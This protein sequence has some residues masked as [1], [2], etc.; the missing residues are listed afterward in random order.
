VDLTT[1]LKKLRLRQVLT[2]F[3]AGLLLVVSTAC[4]SVNAQGA[5]PEN[6]PVQSGGA[7]NPYKSGGDKYTKYNMSTDS[8]VNNTGR[9]QSS[10]LL[11]PQLLIANNKRSELLYPG[12]ETPEGRVYKEQELP[13]KTLKDFQQ[14]EPGGL[15]Q[16][17][18]DVGTRVKER[19]GTVKEAFEEASEF[20]KDKADEATSRPELQ[21]NPAL[22]K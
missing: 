12:A 21:R 19:I 1:F 5:K 6:P 8:K 7:N 4:G 16:N 22:G 18:P 11:N 13:I 20:L 15:I 10:L 9:D 3:F 14:P 17:E 2:V